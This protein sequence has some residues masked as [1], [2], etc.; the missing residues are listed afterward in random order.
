MALVSLGGIIEF[1]MWPTGLKDASTTPGNST[2]N[3][4]TD[5]YAVTVHILEAGTIDKVHFRVGSSVGTDTIRV[6]FQNLD[7]NLVPDG[8]DTHWRDYTQT[9]TED[10]SIIE[11]GL[12]T[13]DGTDVGNKKVVSAGDTFAVVI[14]YQTWTSGS[15]AINQWNDDSANYATNNAWF[16]NDGATF[17]ISNYLSV[18]PSVM[19]EYNDGSFPFQEGTIAYE[20]GTNHTLDSA[21]T[22]DEYAL[23]II[24]PF[25]CRAVG[26]FIKGGTVAGVTGTLYDAG[27][28]VLG[29]GAVSAEIIGAGQ[30]RIR[31][32]HFSSPVT[33]TKDVVYRIAWKPPASPTTSIIHTWSFPDANMREIFP[34]GLNM[35][36]STRVDSGSWTDSTTNLMCAGFLIDQIEAG[37]SGAAVS[38]PGILTPVKSGGHVIY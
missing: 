19:L 21:D 1:P 20:T 3:S 36:R 26:I 15:L 22:P 34:N 5:T 13:D 28:T 32:F 2:L 11:T 23:R 27:D 25:P 17:T 30:N 14:T 6:S 8:T 16:D 10:N 38:A 4:A 31:Y 37:A 18:N 7:A 33:L 35:Q 29:G 24:V 9:G 12:I